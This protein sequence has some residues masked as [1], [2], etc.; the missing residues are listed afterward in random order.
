MCEHV[1]SKVDQQVEKVKTVHISS[2]QI[3]NMPT[4]CRTKL[5]ENRSGENGPPSIVNNFSPVS[6][7]LLLHL[8]LFWGDQPCPTQVGSVSPSFGNQSKRQLRLSSPSSFVA[9]YGWTTRLVRKMS[10]RVPELD[11]DRRT[12]YT[13][14]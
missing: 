11:Y 3:I 1:A 7:S 6:V 13:Q 14:P 2:Y 12:G 9:R 10:L 5:R 8:S 4:P